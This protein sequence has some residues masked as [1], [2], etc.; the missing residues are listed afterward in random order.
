ML[1]ILVPPIPA[2]GHNSRPDAIQVSIEGKFSVGMRDHDHVPKIRSAWINLV[3]AVGASVAQRSGWGRTQPARQL[4]NP[5]LEA[6]TG[7][8]IAQPGD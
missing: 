4:H 7:L 1:P 5:L 3:A 8:P 6:D 2:T